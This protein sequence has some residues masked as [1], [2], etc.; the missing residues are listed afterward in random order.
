VD[1]VRN[2]VFVVFGAAYLGGFQYWLQIN[3]FK[4][5][6]PNMQRFANQGFAAK[7]KDVPGQIDM[8]KQVTDTSRPILLAS[9][10]LSN[11]RANPPDANHP[12]CWARSCSMC[13]CTCRSCTSPSSTP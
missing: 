4:I 10:L 13:W 6:F 11:P 1:W 5:M 2:G 3:M 8:V 7:L 12:F 9:D